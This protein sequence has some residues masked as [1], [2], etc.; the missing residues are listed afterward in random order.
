MLSVVRTIT[1]ATHFGSYACLAPGFAGLESFHRVP[2]A[3]TSHC[4]PVDGWL[5][6]LTLFDLGGLLSQ[7]IS[8]PVIGSHEVEEKWQLRVSRSF[9]L[10][11]TSVHGRDVK[12]TYLQY[13][14]SFSCHSYSRFHTRPVWNWFLLIMD[15]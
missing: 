3:S 8:L 13:S 2:D 1:A 10:I 9:G 11:L 7:R 6:L 5:W 15:S 4:Q 12:N 14:P